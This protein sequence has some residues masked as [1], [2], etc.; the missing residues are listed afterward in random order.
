MTKNE[1]SEEEKEKGGKIVRKLRGE[2]EKIAEKMD[3]IDSLHAYSHALTIFIQELIGELSEKFCFAETVKAVESGAKEERI[4]H[5]TKRE[6]EKGDP[7]GYI[8]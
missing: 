8:K 3:E 6:E 2:T 7:S 4:N 1:L 5:L